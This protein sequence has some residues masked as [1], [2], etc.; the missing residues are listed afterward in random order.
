VPLDSEAGY[1]RVAGTSL[2]ASVNLN[3]RERPRL[4]YQDSEL[5]Y[6]TPAAPARD[7][8]EIVP[9]ISSTC[10][11]DGTMGLPGVLIIRADIYIAMTRR[12]GWGST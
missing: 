9:W 5:E 3:K 7:A 10:I 2:R 11:P 12:V 1:G 6:L 8:R 4:L